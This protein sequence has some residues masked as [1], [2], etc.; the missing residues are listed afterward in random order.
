[1]RSIRSACITLPYVPFN[2]EAY[3]L[4]YNG[5]IQR[6]SLGRNV[7]FISAA[8]SFSCRSE[9]RD[10]DILSSGALEWDEFLRFSINRQVIS[11]INIGRDI[12]VAVAGLPYNSGA[13]NLPFEIS[14]F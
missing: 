9:K 4:Q 5:R 13:G 14:R 6:R 1:M 11:V 2:A 12:V 10:I 7:G 8:E 3:S